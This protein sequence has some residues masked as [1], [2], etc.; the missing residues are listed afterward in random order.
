MGVAGFPTLMASD[1]ERLLLLTYGY[2][3]LAD[4]EAMLAAALRRFADARP[5]GEEGSP[6]AAG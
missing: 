4:V 3:P 2:R 5:D 6:P 1:G